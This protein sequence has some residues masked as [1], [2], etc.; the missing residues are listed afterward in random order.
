MAVIIAMFP[1]RTVI[2]F[3]VICSVRVVMNLVAI[4]D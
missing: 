2:V 4:L 1:E 3:V